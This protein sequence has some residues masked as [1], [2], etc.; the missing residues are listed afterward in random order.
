MRERP[1]P[2][3]AFAF[4]ALAVIATATLAADKRESRPVGAFSGIALAVPA[5]LEIVQGD[6]ESLT[7][8]GPEDVLAD[9][10]TEVRSDGV[11]AIRKRTRGSRSLRAD[12]V[13]IVANMRRVESLAIAGLGDIHAKTVRSPKL[14]LVV[15]GSGKIRLPAVDADEANVKINGSGDVRIAGRAAN[16]ASSIAGSGDLKAERLETR[17]AAVH[18]AGAGDAALWVRDSLEVKIAGAGDVRYYGDP[19]IEKRIAG[20]G[21]VKRMGLAP[22]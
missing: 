16:L 19:S 5:K 20:S 1:Q 11:L 9:I 2:F 7:L 18:I 14:A 8:E 15:S 21:S 6:T 10:E 17:K 13:R 22:S 3:A 4:M 12:D